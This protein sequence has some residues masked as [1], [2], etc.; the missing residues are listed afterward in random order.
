MRKISAPVFILLFL[1]TLCFATVPTLAYYNWVEY[2]GYVY[3]EW[4][5]KVV[6]AK[7]TLKS[8]YITYGKDYTDA[9]GYYYI[10]ALV[11]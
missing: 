10:K 3:D 5:N 6:S 4:Y 9:N 11:S 1:A 2:E 8:G 7:V